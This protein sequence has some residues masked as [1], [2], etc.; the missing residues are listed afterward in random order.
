MLVI[1]DG[2]D[3]RFECILDITD[4]GIGKRK[5]QMPVRFLKA[6]YK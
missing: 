3:L 6:A 2:L 5:H 4:I 1:P